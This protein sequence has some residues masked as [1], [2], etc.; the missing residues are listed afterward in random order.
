VHNHLHGISKKM[1][2]TEV[3]RYTNPTKN[4]WWTKVHRK[5]KQLLLH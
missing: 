4:R 3:C 2:Y 5:D 1:M